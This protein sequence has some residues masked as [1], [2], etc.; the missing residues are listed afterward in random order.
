MCE[1]GPPTIHPVVSTAS[2]QADQCSGHLCMP[3]D[4]R[5]GRPPIPLSLC[6]GRPLSVAGHRPVQLPAH[7]DPHAVQS[8]TWL[9]QHTSQ[10][11]H[12]LEH[13]ADSPEARFGHHFGQPAVQLGQGFD[14]RPARLRQWSP[15]EVGSTHAVAHLTSQFDENGQHRQYRAS[16]QGMD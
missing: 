7:C 14:Q 2:S 8:S 6:S 3:L 5:S 9:S 12:L 11:A 10:P 16:G 13:P 1:H 4:H 15:A